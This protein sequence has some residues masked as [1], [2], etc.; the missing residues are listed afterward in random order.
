MKKI[1]TDVEYAVPG[2]MRIFAS[3]VYDSLLLAA[4]SITYGAIVVGLR[5]LIMGQ[6]EVGQRIRWDMVSSILITLGWLS[7]L[8]FFYIYFWHKFGQTLG[9]KTWRLQLV[10]AQTNQLPSYQQSIK[11]SFCALLSLILFGFG[12]WYR[13]AN[14]QQRLMHDVFSGTKLILLKKK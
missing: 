9:M 7:V 14:P 3:M 12:Y 11:R 1:Q 13:F 5:I 4:I 8:M 10:D 2:F 6:P